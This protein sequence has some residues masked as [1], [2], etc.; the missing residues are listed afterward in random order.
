MQLITNVQTQIIHCYKYFIVSRNSVSAN[1]DVNTEHFKYL[2]PKEIFQS[3]QWPKMMFVCA[4]G[5]NAQKMRCFKNNLCVDR[6]YIFYK[7][8]SVLLLSTVYKWHKTFLPNIHTAA[9]LTSCTD[10]SS[11]FWSSG[12][13]WFRTSLG[14]RS[15]YLLKT[16]CNT[17]RRNA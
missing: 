2:S 9:W 16:T 5:R 6:A 3:F 11:G 7:N 10:S 12:A 15:V 8:Y 1:L 4:K 14:R 13:S 17:A